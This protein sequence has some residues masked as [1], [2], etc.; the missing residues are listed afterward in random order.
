MARL[1]FKSKITRHSKEAHLELLWNFPLKKS[2]REAPGQLGI[3]LG[4]S[5]MLSKDERRWGDHQS[6][7]S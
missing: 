7:I 4:S 2:G 5:L 3:K 1:P 6:P